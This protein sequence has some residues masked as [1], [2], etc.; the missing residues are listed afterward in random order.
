MCKYLVV[1]KVVK[2][3]LVYVFFFREVIVFFRGFWGLL[4]LSFEVG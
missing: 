1:F 2:F 4:F 3:K